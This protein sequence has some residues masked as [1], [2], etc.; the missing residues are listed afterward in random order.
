MVN[1]RTFLQQAVSLDWEVLQMHVH[2]VFLHG[3]LDEEVYMQFPPG[4]RTDDKT[5]ACHLRKSLYG[6]KQA[7]RCLLVC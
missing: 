6:L 1:V 3:D 2:N 4:F 7:P 5:K